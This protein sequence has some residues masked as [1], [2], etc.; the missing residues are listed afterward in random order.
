MTILG[1]N[2]YGVTAVLT[3]TDSTAKIRHVLHLSAKTIKREFH[4]E[5][6]LIIMEFTLQG[7]LVMN[8]FMHLCVIFKIVD[9]VYVIHT[10]NLTQSSSDAHL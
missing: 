5:F 6:K 8:Q 1:L 9:F 2:Q 7:F 4:N 10:L 3:D